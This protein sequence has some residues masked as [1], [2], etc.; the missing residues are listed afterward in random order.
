[1]SQPA[2]PDGT[3]PRIVIPDENEPTV[4]IAYGYSTGKTYHT[5]ECPITERMSDPNHVA[6]SVAEWKGYTKCK[7]CTER[8]SGDG[9]EHPARGPPT[10]AHPAQLLQGVTPVGCVQ[11]RACLLDGD[12]RSDA[13]SRL[14]VGKS[15][16]GR[17][18]LGKCNCG[19][20]AHTLTHTDDG[21]TTTDD[22]GL[23]TYITGVTPVDKSACEMFRRALVKEGVNANT[24]ATVYGVS[25]DA[26]RRHARG[27]CDHDTDVPPA[28]YHDATKSWQPAGVSH[29]R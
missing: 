21:Y 15:T 23:E 12:S 10:G 13:A 19:H 24:L 18:A 1:M 5:T 6:I 4:T 8:E 27:R 29:E 14:D 11:L 26:I 2:K 28:T 7:R 22:G 20:D 9:Y 16:I 3:D 17:H 25:D